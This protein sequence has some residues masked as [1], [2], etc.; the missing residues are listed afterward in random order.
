VVKV[1]DA[2]RGDE[3]L[4]LRGHSQAVSGVAF[5]PDGHR[6]ASAGGDQTI[7]VWDAVREPEGPR[8]TGHAGPV[9]ALALSP[10]GRCCYTAANTAHGAEVHAWLTDTARRVVDYRGPASPV[11]VLAASADGR[12]LACGRN[13][14]TIQVW[15]SATGLRVPLAMHHVGAVRGLAFTP[16]GGRLVSVGLHRA[17]TFGQSDAPPWQQDI[18]VCELATG[19]VEHVVSHPS[20][21]WPRAL[22]VDPRGKGVVVGDDRG[23]IHHWGLA[24]LREMADWQ[25]HERVISGLAFRSNGQWLASASWDNTVRVWDT[26]SHGMVCSLRG[27]SRAVLA[28]A[29]SPDGRRLASAGEDR[30]V[31]LWNAESGWETLSLVG[32]ADIVTALAFSPD[33]RRLVSASLDGTVKVWQAGD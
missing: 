28:V 24:P 33:G 8:Y 11:N 22:A 23:T 3:L 15:E 2:R 29:F 32:H 9:V 18:Q 17:T 1:W 20:V 4:T 21:I 30:T 25:A 16:G 6:L 19:K 26:T 31:K 10:D 7:K 12:L 27:H 13:D 14:G 5:S